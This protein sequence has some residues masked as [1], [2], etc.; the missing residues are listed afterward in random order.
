[1]KRVGC[2]KQ[3]LKI[4]PGTSGEHLCSGRF[5]SELFDI[6]KFRY[7]LFCLPPTKSMPSNSGLGGFPIYYVP[8]SR[9]VLKRTPLEE[10]GTNPSRGVSYTRFL[11][12]EHSK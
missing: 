1:M 9:T 4:N 6:L 11:M 10:P 2:A 8:S 3:H 5:A 12:R 7:N